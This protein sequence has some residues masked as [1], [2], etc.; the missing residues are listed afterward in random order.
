MKGYSSQSIHF[1]Q[2]M[3]KASVLGETVRQVRELKN[4]VKEMKGASN[5]SLECVLPGELNSLSFGFSEKDGNLVKATFSCDDRPE[6]IADLTREIRKV[7]GTIV[8]AE[9]VFIGGRNKSVLWIKGFSG[10]ERM[11][12]LKRALKMAIDIPKKNWNPRFNI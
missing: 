8:R 11:G 3:D 12:M 1:V 9:M 10:N 6:L 4:R 7:S 5:G 2:Q